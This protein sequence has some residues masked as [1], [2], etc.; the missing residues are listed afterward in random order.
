MKFFYPIIIILVF[1]GCKQKKTDRDYSG[2]IN[3]PTA[4]NL[5]AEYDINEIENEIT[6]NNFDFSKMDSLGHERSQNISH[7]FGEIMGV[8]HQKN[9]NYILLDSK[10]NEIRF[11][12]K[13]LNLLKIQKKAGRGP[14]EFLSPQKIIMDGNYLFIMDLYHKINKY[15]V[16]D[17][18]LTYIE[19]LNLKFIPVD[20][21]LS[22]NSIF[23]RGVK[24]KDFSIQ[25]NSVN[26]IHEY[27]ISTFKYIGS[28]GNSYYSNNIRVIVRLSDGPFKVFEDIL[29]YSHENFPYI[30]SQD[31]KTQEILWVS[32]LND[33][34]EAKIISG[35]RKNGRDFARYEAA[36][37]RSEQIISIQDWDKENILVQTQVY[38]INS[39]KYTINKYLINKYTG[40]GK[41]ISFNPEEFILNFSNDGI[42]TTN[43]NGI[44]K[45]YRYLK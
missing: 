17:D 39:K 21:S 27:D 31:L 42:L 38:H 5:F 37:D 20:I 11:Y 33:F 29:I 26:I 30:I 34:N 44:P 13:K 19:S 9:Q 41:P 1:F 3:H 45:L 7:I 2:H 10:F 14:G 23:V 18:S 25:N 12:D 28:Y 8:V 16:T 35:K 36:G 32:K 4:D 22:G 6:P 24:S 15:E 40:T 43:I